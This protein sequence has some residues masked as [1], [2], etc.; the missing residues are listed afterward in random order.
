VGL[1]FAVVIAATIAFAS[2]KSVDWYEAPG[3]NEAIKQ[4][5]P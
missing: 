5:K 1:F 2:W 3:P 4:P